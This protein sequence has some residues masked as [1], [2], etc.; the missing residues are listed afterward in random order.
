MNRMHSFLAGAP[1]KSPV[2]VVGK[3][4]LFVSSVPSSPLTLLPQQATPPP[5]C[6]THVWYSPAAIPTTPVEQLSVGDN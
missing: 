3:V 1:C 6:T 2:T 4:L 5:D